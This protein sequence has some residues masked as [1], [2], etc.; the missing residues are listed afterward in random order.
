[1]RPLKSGNFDI[2][3]KNAIQKFSLKYA[4]NTY[5]LK[6]FMLMFN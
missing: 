6:G 2:S 1:M 5:F 4:Y 3:N